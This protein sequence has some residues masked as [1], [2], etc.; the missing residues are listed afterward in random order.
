M[1]SLEY[2][3]DG[4]RAYGRKHAQIAA[5]L[6][7]AAAVDVAAD[8]ASLTPV[9]GL[10]GSEFLAAFGT[11]LTQ[12]TQ[13]FTSIVEYYAGS[14]ALAHATAASYDHADHTTAAALDAADQ[15]RA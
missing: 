5:E 10:V 4:I 1:A 11:A 8:V 2:S 15:G 13:S 6:A 14:A 7:P 3:S 9:F 12:H